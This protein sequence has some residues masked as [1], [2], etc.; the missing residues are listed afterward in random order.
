M[1][2][3]EESVLHDVIPSN[4]QLAALTRFDINIRVIDE[5]RFLVGKQD[6]DAPDLLY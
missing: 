3:V 1:I 2:R 6:A 5:T 4:P